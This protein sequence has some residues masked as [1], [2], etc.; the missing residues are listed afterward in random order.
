M[1]N[2]LAA[3]PVTPRVDEPL[4]RTLPRAPSST[5]QQM[6]LS[7]SITPRAT[8]PPWASSYDQPFVMPTE[9]LPFSTYVATTPELA[10]LKQA[11]AHYYAVR[12]PKLSD[13]SSTIYRSPIHL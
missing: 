9:P 5:A 11:P 3:L 2:R 6:E 1:I 8:K 7:S 13:A 4:A 12:D 10:Q